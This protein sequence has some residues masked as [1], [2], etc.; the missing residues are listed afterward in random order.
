MVTILRLWRNAS[1]ILARASVATALFWAALSVTEAHAEYKLAAGDSIELSISGTD[2]KQRSTINID[3]E[4]AFPLLGSLKVAGL[5]LSEVRGMLQ[6]LMPK[7]ALRIRDSSGHDVVSVV[8]PE[9]IILNVAE[10]R[11]VYLDGDVSKPGEQVFRPSM[12]VRQAVAM[13]GGYDIAQFR[14]VN[15]SLE[16]IDLRSEYDVL[17]A[18]YLRERV[19]ISRLNAELNGKSTV[20]KQGEIPPIAPSLVAEIINLENDLLRT[21]SG[22]Y[23]KEKAYLKSAIQQAET[24]RLFL[25]EQQRKEEEGV[26]LDTADLTRL[27]ALLDR[28]QGTVVRVT[29]ARRSL[30]LSST[31]QLQTIAQASQIELQ[32]YELDRK[33]QKVDDD[34]RIQVTRELQDATAEFNRIRSRL[35]A[36]SEKMLYVG[37]VKTALIRGG[38]K[39]KIVLFRRTGGE[40]N[41]IVADE[42]TEL[43][44]GDVVQ[45]S[46][47]VETA[48]DIGQDEKTSGV[49]P[50]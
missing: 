41:T 46:L 35:Q 49:P 6:Q 30:L 26:Q 2:L 28:G 11:P 23:T 31:R 4:V 42:S 47:K 40:A 19:R 12:T 27:K 29:D 18:A 1:R 5:P 34:R 50:E 21:R 37:S 38:G 7:Q 39:P 20:D 48:S 9:Q 13:A 22:D 36:V 15:P 3:G 32:K 8:D 24:R 17:W 14:S 43:A 45:I 25:E 33:L 44:P 16:V 10:Y